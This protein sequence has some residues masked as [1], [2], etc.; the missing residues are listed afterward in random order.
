MAPVKCRKCLF[1]N[2]SDA[3]LPEIAAAKK[4]LVAL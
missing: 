3:G 1:D 4:T 2:P